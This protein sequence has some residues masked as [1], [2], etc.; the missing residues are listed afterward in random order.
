MLAAGAIV[1]GCGGSS[2]DGATTLRWFISNEPSGAPVEAA[3][4]CS[5]QSDGRYEIEFRYLPSS[6]DQQREQLVRRLA[7][8]DDTID[9]IGM[10]VIWTG[11]FANAGWLEPVPEARRERLTAEVFQSV[12]NT[13]EFEGHL[14]N[15]PIWS[16]TQ[17]LWYRK[18]RV[19]QAPETWDEMLAQSARLGANGDVLVQANRYEGLVVWANAMI[20]SAGTSILSGPGEVELERRRPSWRSRRWRAPFGPPEP[21]STPRRRTPPAS[22]SSRAARRSCSTTP[23]STPRRRRTRPRS[24]AT[25]RPRST[26]RSSTASRASRRWAASTSACRRSRITSSSRSK[27]S[28]A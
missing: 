18:D 12:L 15:V 21:A 6:A 13:A 7:A 17:L 19:E 2:G 26:P 9:L 22:P 3:Q 10:D 27:R 16:N 23:S 1:V 24:S 25:W 4:R 11:E 28:S 14:Y 5:E 8:E 20:E